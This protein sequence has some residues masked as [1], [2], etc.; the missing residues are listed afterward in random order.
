MNH[1]LPIATGLIVRWSP[2]VIVFGLFMAY[3]AVQAPVPGVNEPQYLGKAKFLWDPHWAAGDFFLE[4]SNPHLAFYLAVGWLTQFL[5]LEASAW[6]ARLAGYAVVAWGWTLLAGGVAGSRWSAVPAAALFLLL[7]SIGN[8]SGEWL[9]GG[10]EGKVFSYGLLFAAIGLWLDRRPTAAAAC[11]GG[12]VSFHPI[13]GVWGLIG[14][15]AA[16]AVFAG[17]GDRTRLPSGRGW[18]RPGCV[19]LA[20]ALPGLI[21]ALLIL[22][23]TSPA[24][25]AR[26]TYMQVFIRL[27]HHLDPTQFPATRYAGYGLMLAVWLMLWVPQCRS[28]DND[29]GAIDEAKKRRRWFLAFVPT[30]V[31]IALVGVAIGWHGGDAWT[32]PLRDLRGTLL[33][34]YPFRL[35]DVF[36]PLALA[37]AV[38]AL[39]TESLAT[40]LRASE[41]ARRPRRAEKRVLVLAALATAVTTAAFVGALLIASPD[42]NPSRM[43]PR[44]LAAW[45]DVAEWVH[46]NTPEDAV[47]VTPSRHW[48]FRWY[49][50]RALY[51]N[52]KDAPQDAAG[53]IEWER[54][55]EVLKEW[56]ESA[57]RGR[58]YRDDLLRL[59]EETGAD[60]LVTRA[61][62]RR[63]LVA[64]VYENAA[65]RVYSLR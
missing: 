13:V 41:S 65:Y 63:F 38:G 57:R 54:R 18:I 33:K 31:A 11:L 30:C 26:A 19:F 51:V 47:I 42:R 22:D 43:P 10:I 49:S 64:P 44:Q 39:V 53:L 56:W 16:E 23:G 25:T 29:Q 4:S 2:A 24:D 48:G 37:L 40:E 36:V 28:T 1:T 62:A 34:F 55:L 50:H 52:F 3:S 5:T 15:A 12:S 9:V 46:R 14:A 32:M 60:Y 17:R 35:A 20:T 27:R 6:I 7:A 8:L 59:G 21:P 61:N 58:F 45:R